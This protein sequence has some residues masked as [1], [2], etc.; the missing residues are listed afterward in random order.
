MGSAGFCRVV[1][2]DGSLMGTSRNG[3]GS[4]RYSVIHAGS[5][6]FI[7]AGEPMECL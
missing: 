1:G 2:D 7:M 5:W 4:N 6:W 3:D